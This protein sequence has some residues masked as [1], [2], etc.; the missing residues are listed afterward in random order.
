VRRRLLLLLALLCAVGVALVTPSAA[1]AHSRGPTLALDVLLEIPSRPGIRIDV[2]DGNRKLRLDVEP[3]RSLVVRGLLGEPFLRFRRDGVWADPRSPTTAADRIV[4]SGHA[5]GWVRLT[6]GHSFSWHDHRLAPP[7]GLPAGST[8]P[9]SLPVFLDGRPTAIDGVFTSVP[10]PAWWPWLAGAVV[11][12]AV[13]LVLARRAPARRTGL[14]W[15]TAVAAAAGAAL[16][17]V[18]FAMEVSV[19]AASQWVQVAFAGVLLLVACSGAFA[20]RTLRSWTASLVGAAAVVLSLRQIVVFWHGVV[21]SALSPTVTR[22]AVAVA[23]AGGIAAAGVSFA[24]ED[25]A[26]ANARE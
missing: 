11:A 19:G 23:L 1:L 3:S 15:L 21:I 12:L 7:R 6:R 25:P 4:S 17:S 2:L 20:R 16:A 26:P 10:R 5:A 18:G 9:F 22:L 13:I 14:A 24:A 8:A